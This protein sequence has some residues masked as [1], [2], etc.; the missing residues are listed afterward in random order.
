MATPVTKETNAGTADKSVKK[1]LGRRRN[2]TAFPLQ[3]KK[4]SPSPE[5]SSHATPSTKSISHTPKTVAE[6]QEMGELARMNDDL[7]WAMDGLDSTSGS[8][9]ED[10]FA[11]LLELLT[12]R[13]GRILVCK[14]GITEKLLDSLVVMDFDGNSMTA[15][16]VACLF[17]L[18]TMNGKIR[19]FTVDPYL[20]L[21]MRVMKFYEPVRLMESSLLA[22]AIIKF[23]SDPVVCRFVPRETSSSPLSICLSCLTFSLQP[24]EEYDATPIK[25]SLGRTN[26]L[27]VI[28]EAAMQ[29]SNALNDPRPTMKTVQGLWKLKKYE[30]FRFSCL[31]VTIFS[32]YRVILLQLF[33]YFGVCLLCMLRK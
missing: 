29:E 27:R 2:S 10:S 5:D 11:S 28:V 17:L 18:F 15:L 7:S 9:R 1:L 21:L 22:K 24:R 8:A 31:H 4:A 14:D 25:K 20:E 3:N 30:Y 33:A 19:I 26:S 23:L 12:S 16:S 6:A 13:R 32:Y